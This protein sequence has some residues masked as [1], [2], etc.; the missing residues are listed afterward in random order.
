MKH[1]NRPSDMSSRFRPDTNHAMDWLFY[2]RSACIALV[3]AFIL[4]AQDAAAPSGASDTLLRQMTDQVT[5]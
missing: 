5:N 1:T 2:F 4:T 3:S